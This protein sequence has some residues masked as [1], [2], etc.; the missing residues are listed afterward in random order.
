MRKMRLQCVTQAKL[1]LFQIYWCEITTRVIMP[2][3]I[4]PWPHGR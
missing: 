4:R 1:D 2:H 3:N